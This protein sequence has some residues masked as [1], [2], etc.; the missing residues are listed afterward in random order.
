MGVDIEPGSNV[1]SMEDALISLF[2]MD[3]IRITRLFE[4]IQYAF[5]FS[6]LA[7]IVGAFL[8]KLFAPMYPIKGDDDTPL[9]SMGQLMKTALIIAVQ[10]V[11]GALSVFYIRKIV[12]VWQRHKE[13]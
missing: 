12:A 7:I 3:R 2:R 5:M 11:L 13:R 6:I 1:G 8:D 4:I 10:V 9:S